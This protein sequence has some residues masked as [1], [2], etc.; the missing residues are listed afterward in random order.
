MI[1][2]QAGTKV[3]FELINPAQQETNTVELTR[4]KFVTSTG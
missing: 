3:R 1:G 2:G 4:Q